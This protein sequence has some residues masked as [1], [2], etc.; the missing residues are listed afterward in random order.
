MNFVLSF[1]QWTQ[2]YFDACCLNRPF[3]DQRQPRVRLEAEA[4]SH[5]LNRQKWIFS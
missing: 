3:D 5:L 1:L 4:I 2:I